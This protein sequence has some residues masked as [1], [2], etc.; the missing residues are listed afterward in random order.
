[1]RLVVPFS[2]LLLALYTHGAPYGAFKEVDGDGSCLDVEGRRPAWGIGVHYNS[3][4]DCEQQCKTC[5]H[6]V[7]YAWHGGSS[8]FRVQEGMGAG[9]CQFF[10]VETG[11]CQ[12][13][14]DINKPA[15]ENATGLIGKTDGKRAWNCYR[16]VQV[17]HDDGA[18]LVQ[19]DTYKNVLCGWQHI[20]NIEGAWT[21]GSAMEAEGVCLAAGH[22]CTGFLTREPAQYALFDQVHHVTEASGVDCHL[23]TTCHEWACQW[24]HANTHHV[25]ISKQ[26][27][28]AHRAVEKNPYHEDKK[29]QGHEDEL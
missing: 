7:G 5:P 19:F 23:S 9:L 1:M 22:N 27:V 11:V 25:D 15:E 28:L 16:R 2:L 6:C 14:V 8:S 29:A 10:A 12:N 13:V 26:E 17:L 20:D 4:H 21:A 3:R 24:L 18:P